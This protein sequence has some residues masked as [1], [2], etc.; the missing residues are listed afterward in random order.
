MKQSLSVQMDSAG[1]LLTTDLI[2]F[3]RNEDY[4]N[5]QKIQKTPKKKK[6][7][8]KQSKK[9]KTKKQKRQKTKTKKTK[10]WESDPRDRPTLNDSRKALTK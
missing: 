3:V 2:S 10:R 7:K 9:Q 4:E 8:T 6:K 1:I 5:K